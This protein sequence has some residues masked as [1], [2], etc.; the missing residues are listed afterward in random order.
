[1]MP[2]TTVRQH[3][4]ATRQL[5]ELVQIA[6]EDAEPTPARMRQAA[7]VLRLGGMSAGGFITQPVFTFSQADRAAFHALLR[8]VLDAI[9]NVEQGGWDAGQMRVG[10]HLFRQPDGRVIRRFT[11][12]ESSN[13]RAVAVLLLAALLEQAGDRL[14]RCPACS[15]VFVRVGRQDYCSKACSQRVRSAK[16]YHAQRER[17]L[18]RRADAY[19]RSR[20]PAKVQPRRLQRIATEGG[21]ARPKGPQVQVRGKKNA[22]KSPTGKIRA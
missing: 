5:A 11:G 7:A 18:A 2:Q 16:H 20:R 22:R 6:Y 8:E 17:I 13:W 12:G 21:T 3:E 15:K 10:I 1:M 19:V 9:V 14:R 4:L